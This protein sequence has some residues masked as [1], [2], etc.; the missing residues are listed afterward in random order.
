MK[1]ILLL[2]IILMG[3]TSSQ[4]RRG[5]KACFDLYSNLS[6]SGGYNLRRQDGYGE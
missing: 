2:L 5:S 1:T 3:C 6:R 4:K